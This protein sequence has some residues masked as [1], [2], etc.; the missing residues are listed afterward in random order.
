[1]NMKIVVLISCVCVCALLNNKVIGNSDK[2]SEFEKPHFATCRMLKENRKLWPTPYPAFWHHVQPRPT[3]ISA[4]QTDS[5]NKGVSAFS[6]TALTPA[7][8]RTCWNGGG[9]YI[10]RSMYECVTVLSFQWRHVRVLHPV[11]HL[12]VYLLCRCDMRSEAPR[13]CRWH[14]RDGCSAGPLGCMVHVHLGW[15]PETEKY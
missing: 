11:A 13:Q 14:K 15:P 5:S 6:T 7:K 10:L 8:V 9:C 1:M 3:D 2:P 12:C 4:K